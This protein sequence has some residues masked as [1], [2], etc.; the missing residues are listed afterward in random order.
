MTLY[1]I[2]TR[3]DSKHEVIKVGFSWPGF[4]FT[5]IWAF[6]KGLWTPG[7][8]VLLA[9]FPVLILGFLLT[10]PAEQAVLDLLFF[11]IQLTISL[12]LGFFGNKYRE[13]SMG[14]RGYTLAL[15]NLEAWNTEHATARLNKQ[16]E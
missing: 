10:H 16:E 4:F 8:L 13:Q 9:N 11:P 2:Y 14:R 12:W 15:S 1:N 6:V 5:W 7:L 3:A